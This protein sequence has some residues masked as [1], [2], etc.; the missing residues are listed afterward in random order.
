MA[1]LVDL[2]GI[3]R[4]G[5]KVVVDPMF[6]AGAGYIPK[7]LSGGST[8]VTEIRGCRNPA[9]P[10]MAQPEPI[11][12]NLKELMSSVPDRGADVGLAT[13]GDG[14]RVGIVDEQGRF[15]T[16]LQ[17]FALMCLHLLDVLGERGP[18]VR[19]ITMTSMVDRLGEEYNVPVFDSPVGF[20]FLGQIMMRENA[21][22]AGEESGGYAFR[23][24]LPERDGILSGLMMLDMMVKTKKTPSELLS[25]LEE[26]L[27]PHHYERWDVTFDPNQRDSIQGPGQ[28]SQPLVAGRQKGREHRHP[29]RRSIRAP[30]RVLGAGPILRHRAAD[31]HLCRG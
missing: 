8:E 25:M 6:G 3:R 18:I 4:A 31:P 30:R 14:D 1:T 11:A 26:K 7:L 22:L 9:F 29:G 27:G 17:A 16:T 13:D 23:G 10:G 2:E 28:E 5:L 20:K 24:H 12:H 19:S 21:L 15:V